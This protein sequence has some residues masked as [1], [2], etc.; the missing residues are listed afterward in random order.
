VKVL[1]Q[2][3]DKIVYPM[4]GAGVIEA[5]E[6]KEIQGTKHQYFVIMMPC[7]NMKVMIP[8]DKVLKSGIRLVEDLSTLKK[9]L[10]LFEDGEVDQT[11]TW[12]QR[13]LYNTEKLKTGEMKA[14]A[15]VI[16]DLFLINKNKTLN[17]S[18]KQLLDQAKK[19]FLSELGIIKKMHE[20]HPFELLNDTVERF[21]IS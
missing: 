15:E 14:G 4:H 16:R 9:V 5:I 11:V 3:G 1:F 10:L 13:H 20:N 2:V 19:I 8:I 21:E 18:E 6:E 12:K 7:S 17:S